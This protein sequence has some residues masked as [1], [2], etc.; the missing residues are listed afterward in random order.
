ME[1]LTMKPQNFLKFVFILV[2]LLILAGQSY[3]GKVSKETKSIIRET[4]QSQVKHPGFSLI[5]DDLTYADVVFTITDEGKL[6]VKKIISDNEALSDYL[7]AN[8]SKVQ[9]LK[10]NS[11]MNQH[12]RIKFSFRF[13]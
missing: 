9:F 2:A 1:G 4:I 8:L 7:K 12:Y 3:A 5:R 6:I 10:V 11:P 13:V